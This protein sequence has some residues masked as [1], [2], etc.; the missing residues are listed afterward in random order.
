MQAANQQVGARRIFLGDKHQIIASRQLA[1]PFSP[2]DC[3]AL[4]KERAKIPG[5]K[6]KAPLKKQGRDKK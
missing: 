6:Q 4:Q 5:V 3:Q 1:D 2:G